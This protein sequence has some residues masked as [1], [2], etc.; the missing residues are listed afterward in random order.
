M[1]EG[2]RVG[3]LVEQGFEDSELAETVRG[4]VRATPVARWPCE[5]FYLFDAGTARVHAGRP[6]LSSM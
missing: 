2:Y 1:L 6:S 3:I 4:I 5:V